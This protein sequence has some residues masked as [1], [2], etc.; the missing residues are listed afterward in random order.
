M[1]EKYDVIVVGLGAMGSASLYQ[2]A[3]RGAK[4]LG[5][6]Q[7]QPPHNMGSSH[8]DTRIIRKVNGEG[9]P[10][11]PLVER[12]YDIWRELEELSGETLFYETGGLIICPKD[13]SAQFHGQQDFVTRTAK[14]ADQFGVDYRL[15][16]PAGIREQTA[17]LVPA[18]SDHA[19]YEPE[20]GILRPER[21][22]GVQ[23]ELAKAKGAT[24]RTGE[25]VLGYHIGDDGVSV[26][27]NL[28]EYHADKLILSSGA[29]MV[30]FM[31]EPYR[32]TLKV[33]RQVIYW[34]EAED[35]SPYMM[36]QLPFV[37]WIGDRLEDFFTVF[38]T[39]EDGV[40]G[41]K[42][43]TE[44]YLE[45]THPE[46]VKRE[47]SAEEIRDFYQTIVKPRAVG[48]TENCLQTGVCLYTVTPDEHFIID[49]HP[50]SERVVLASPCSGHGFKHSAAIG[51]V[52][53][54]MALDGTS[55]LDIRLFSLARF[56]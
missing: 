11:F 43:L 3:K 14:L 12:A 25:R 20:G 32:D 56:D 18:E 4:V 36:D 7:F 54:Q 28:G 17:T 16:D 6:D 40:Q 22:V 19:Y 34:F 55:E 47:V 52:L 24:V 37:I 8:G 10:Y 48:I 45:T 49:F 15:L 35:L 9:A 33:Y 13:D 51:E 42:V 27:S 38:P 46:Q 2:L 50:E 26:H 23:L 30:D 41:V 39:P 31:P 44:Q 53:A 29:W 21:C 5:I 1:D